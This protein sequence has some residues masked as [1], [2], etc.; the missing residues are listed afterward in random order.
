M[1]VIRKFTAKISLPALQA[2]VVILYGK[3]EAE[4]VANLHKKL[5]THGSIW[6][7]TLG[8]GNYMIIGAF[9]RSMSGN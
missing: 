1:G 6:W 7:V 8:G 5:G 9:L 3:S 2:V 4:S